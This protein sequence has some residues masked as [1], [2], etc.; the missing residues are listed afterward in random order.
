MIRVIRVWRL[1]SK[2]LQTMQTILKRQNHWP[3]AITRLPHIGA[4]RP[5][6]FSPGTQACQAQV[7]I[8]L[9]L[10]LRQRPPF[11]TSLSPKLWSASLALIMQM[12]VGTE[13]ATPTTGLLLLGLLG[14]LCIARLC[15]FGR[16]LLAAA[17]SNLTASE[18]SAKVLEV[19]DP[20]L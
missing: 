16:G 6:A 5:E 2:V 3:W 12:Y 10:L 11:F 19:C 20:G 9:L 7:T 8:G 4:E 13:W 1:E 14:W 18:F 17:S 15:R